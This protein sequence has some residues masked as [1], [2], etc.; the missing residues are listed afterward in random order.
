MGLTRT[1]P[2]TGHASTASNGAVAAVEPVGPVVR[3]KN[4]TLFSSSAGGG[5]SA[6]RRSGPCLNANRV[7]GAATTFT[8]P[9]C[10][11][12][13]RTANGPTGSGCAFAPDFGLGWRTTA[14]TVQSE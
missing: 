14:V 6:R 2:S 12:T 1:A 9:V 10:R 4:A 3:R 13:S 8:V 7:C 5:G 11:R